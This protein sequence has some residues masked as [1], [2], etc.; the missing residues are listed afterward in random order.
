MTY[1]TIKLEGLFGSARGV[2]A[3]FSKKITLLKN[4]NVATSHRSWRF[5]KKSFLWTHKTF[6]SKI[7]NFF[8]NTVKVG[9]YGRTH[10]GR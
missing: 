10:R 1:F 6:F 9:R 5:I 4:V 2:Y 8:K 7:D 3:L